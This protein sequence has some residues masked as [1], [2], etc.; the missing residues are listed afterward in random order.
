MAAKQPRSRLWTIAYSHDGSKFVRTVRARTGLE[1]ERILR[2]HYASI[3]G[4]GFGALAEYPADIDI[5]VTTWATN[6]AAVL[7][8]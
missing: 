5:Y 1:A 8:R 6:A 2:E 7:N 3:Y 4:T